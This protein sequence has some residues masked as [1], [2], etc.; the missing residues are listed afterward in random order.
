M[1]WDY[2]SH[3]G[4]MEAYRDGTDGAYELAMSLLRDQGGPI[5]ADKLCQ[6]D[7]IST[8]VHA[9]RQYDGGRR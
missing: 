7:I 2:K 9:T 3:L 4:C 1:T 6:A 5:W 8:V